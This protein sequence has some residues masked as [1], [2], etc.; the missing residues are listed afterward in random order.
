MS[1]AQTAHFLMTFLMAAPGVALVVLASRR[2]PNE[3][4]ERLYLGGGD[5]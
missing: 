1:C 4:A 3:N 2:P 5:R